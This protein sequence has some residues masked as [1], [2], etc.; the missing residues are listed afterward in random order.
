M[1]KL[2]KHIE[3]QLDCMLIVVYFLFVASY[4][5]ISTLDSLKPVAT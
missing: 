4:L 2:G 5:A 3:I 1:L